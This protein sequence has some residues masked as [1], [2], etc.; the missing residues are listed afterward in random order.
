MKGSKPWWAPL[1]LAIGVSGC[2]SL[3]PGQGHAEVV[4]LVEAHGRSLASTPKAPPDWLREKLAQ[5]LAPDDAVQIALT[6]SPRIQAEYARLG[7]ASAEVYSAGRLSNP[8]LSA[9]VLGSNQSGAA[10]QVTFGLAQSFASL[11][12]LPARGRF[13]RGDFERMKEEIAAKIL[14]LAAE[15]ESA[16][17]DLAGA[18]QVSR[19]RDSVARSARASADLAQRFLD[20]GNITRLEW[21]MQQAEASQAQLD[22]LTA[23]ADVAAARTTLARLM[24]LGPGVSDWSIPSGVPAPLADED[25]LTGLLRLAGESRLDLS[26]ARKEAQLLADSLGVT[27]RFRYLGEVEVGVETERETDRSRLTGPTLSLEL[28]LFNHGQGAV[29]RAQAQ[30]E[31]A[32]ARLRELEIAAANDVK[33][34][35]ARVANAKARAQAYRTSLIPQREEIVARSQEQ[36]NFM[37]QGQFALLLAKRQEYEAYQGYLEVVRDYWLARIELAKSVGTQ[38]PSSRQASASVLDAETLTQP[39]DSGVPNMDHGDGMGSMNHSGHSMEMPEPAGNQKQDA[40]QHHN[41]GDTP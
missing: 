17:F 12:M 36:V 8:K 22:A 27:R 37:L 32:E 13:A 35:H 34:A 25:E 7:I 24:G 3:P 23:Q 28:P 14:D 2:V 9:A 30:L 11:L 6:Q 15:V 21:A 31:S 29:A 39:D 38:L 41:H 16:W 40:H 4:S 19:M 10:D 18:Q 26:A 20:A 5:P 33:L 1:A